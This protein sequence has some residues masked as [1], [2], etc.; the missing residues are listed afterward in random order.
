M[1]KNQENVD[2]IDNLRK[3]MEPKLIGVVGPEDR[4]QQAQVLLVPQGMTAVAVKS[5]LDAYLERPERRS[6]IEAADRL[7][8]FIALTN[9]FKNADS[10]IFAKGE[11]LGNTLNARLAAVLNYHPANGDNKDAQ[12]GDH[13]VRYDFPVSKEFAFWLGHN[14]K[15]MNQADFAMFLEQRTVEMVVARDEDAAEIANLKP[16]FADPLEMLELARNL[17]IYS[18][19]TVQQGYK[20]NSGERSVKFNAVHNGADGKP[21]SIPDFFMLN[22]PIFTAEKPQ[23]VIV[24]LRYRKSGEQI[25]WSYDLFRVD[26]VFDRAFNEAVEKAQKE[27]SLPVFF[28]TPAD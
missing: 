1:S 12:H 20:P 28:G 21:I 25:S 2:L 8:S 14:G 10:V 22:V 15:P 9:R 24:H 26:R 5:F 27:T 16:K 7:E 6:G 17:Q 4:G 13:V 19:E 18:S 23:R 11:I 3:T